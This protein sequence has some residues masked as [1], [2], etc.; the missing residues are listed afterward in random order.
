[1]NQA[2]IVDAVRIPRA[3]AKGKEG[4]YGMLKPV[5]LLEP[6]FHAIAARNQLDSH[7]VEDV[8]LGCNTQTD[9]QGANLAKISALYAGWPDKVSGVTINRFCCSYRRG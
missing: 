2:Y 9:Q 4:A 1:M 7:Q 3:R 8:L 5:E 6:L